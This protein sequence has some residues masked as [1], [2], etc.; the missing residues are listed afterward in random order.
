MRV[1]KNYLRTHVDEFVNEEQ[2]A[3]KHLLVDKYGP[4]CLSGDH[5][6]DAY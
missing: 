3:F 1:A 6:D 2:S 5:K 4:F